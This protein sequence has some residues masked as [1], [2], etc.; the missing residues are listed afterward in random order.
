MD[1]KKRTLMVFVSAIVIL[2]LSGW[3]LGKIGERREREQTRILLSQLLPQ[4]Q[5]FAE[6]ELTSDAEHVTQAWRGETGYVVETVMNGYVEDIVV[7]TA[8][9]HEGSVTGVTIRTLHETWG[10]GRRALRDEEFLRQFLGTDGYAQ[11]GYG[12]DGLTG[13]T[14]TSKAI[15]RAINAAAAF[16]SGTDG[17]T[18]ATEW[19]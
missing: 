9:D 6:E 10:L 5:T 7:W 15:A 16:V 1:E 2:I 4:S 17:L 18:E 19:G 11:I 13:A 12:I 14:V 3:L 8:L